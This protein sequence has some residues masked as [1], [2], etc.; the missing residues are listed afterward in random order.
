MRRLW[1]GLLLGSLLGG[2]AYLVTRRRPGAPLGRGATSARGLGHRVTRSLK[3]QLRDVQGAV[4]VGRRIA[5]RKR[6]WDGVTRLARR[7]QLI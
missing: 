2:L 1:K 5:R 6:L 3:R 4:R 7:L